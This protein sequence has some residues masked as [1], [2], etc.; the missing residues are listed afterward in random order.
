MARSLTYTPLEVEAAL[1]VWEWMID[2]ADKELKDFFEGHGWGC[3]R[4]L[5][6]DLGRWCQQVYLKAEETFEFDVCFD[7][8]LVP[9]MMQMIDFDVAIESQYSTGPEVFPDVDESAAKL[10]AAYR[11]GQWR[12]HAA[13]HARLKYAVDLSDL[14]IDEPILDEDPTACVNRLA[15]K[16]GLEAIR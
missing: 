6:T 12:Y 3:M 2:R 13:S 8:E 15:E 11:P 14:G 7:W 5:A 9:S 4:L 10:I 1:C 16:Y